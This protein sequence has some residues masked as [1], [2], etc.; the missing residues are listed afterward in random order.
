M[1]G[2]R[3]SPSYEASL[4]TPPCTEDV[5]LIGMGT[6]VELG[7]GQID[8][9][10]ARHTGNRPLQPLNDREVHSADGQPADP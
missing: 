8:T 9:L 4:T 5:L 3:A 6:P 7:K 10:E 1:P 2:C